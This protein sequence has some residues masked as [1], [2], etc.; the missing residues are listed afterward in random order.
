MEAPHGG[1]GGSG[2]SALKAANLGEIKQSSFESTDSSNQSSHVIIPMEE[3]GDSGQPPQLLQQQRPAAGPTARF[4]HFRKSPLQVF[5]KDR[6]KDSRDRD[7][8]SLVNAPVSTLLAHS[9][10]TPLPTF[11]A[12]FALPLNQ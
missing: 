11:S 2:K 6:D 5:A 3:D 9:A 1:G 7:N 12:S 10:C 8:V 4:F